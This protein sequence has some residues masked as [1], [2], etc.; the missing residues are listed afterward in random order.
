MTPDPAVPQFIFILFPLPRGKFNIFAKNEKGWVLYVTTHSY[1]EGI[2]WFDLNKNDGYL[3]E[4]RKILI[5]R[6]KRMWAR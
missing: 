5:Y 4:R 2:R 1:G 6:K 3:E